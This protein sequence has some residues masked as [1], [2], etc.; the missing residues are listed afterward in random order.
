[1]AMQSND[2][3]DADIVQRARE[4]DRFGRNYDLE[5]SDVAATQ[6]PQQSGLVFGD[7][8]RDH[9]AERVG[10]GIDASACSRNHATGQLG[11][12]RASITRITYRVM[13]GDSACRNAYAR[14]EVYI[15]KMIRVAQF[16]G[17]KRTP[18]IAPPSSQI[19][20]G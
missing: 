2:I 3:T 11:L 10:G 19:Q 8:R 20:Q 12:V 7:G 15:P 17:I 5:R 1:M 6:A 18:I 4:C 9:D 14:F 16:P 13:C